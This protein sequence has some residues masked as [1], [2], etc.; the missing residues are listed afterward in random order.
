MVIEWYNISVNRR[1]KSTVWDCNYNNTRCILK[2]SSPMRKNN[3][4]DEIFITKKAQVCENVVEFIEDGITVDG[5][6]AMILK[7]IEGVQA[8]EFVK[9]ATQQQVFSLIL[10][11]MVINYQLSKLGVSFNDWHMLNVIITP[12][13][14]V[15]L[16]CDISGTLYKIPT[17]GYKVT[18]VDFGESILEAYNSERK[19]LI[20]NKGVTHALDNFLASMLF[21]QDCLS[22]CPQTLDVVKSFTFL[23]E[24]TNIVTKLI[25]KNYYTNMGL[26]WDQVSKYIY[27]SKESR[28]IFSLDAQINFNTRFVAVLVHQT[29]LKEL[30]LDVATVISVQ[31]VFNDIFKHK[32][33]LYINYI[34]YERKGKS[35]ML[36]CF[37]RT[38]EII[39]S[40]FSKSL[41]SVEFVQTNVS[42]FKQLDVKFWFDHLLQFF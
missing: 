42:N 20:F 38:R 14:V 32:G 12:T 13:S 25:R 17:C 40:I 18:V 41:D 9:C 7:Y 11:C 26:F 6:P 36:D 28:D 4:L 39:G 27:A 24:K 34:L 23:Y 1:I 35:V 33:G 2:L 31:N 19:S 30:S 8:S 5:L 16:E 37:D 21:Y 29:P 10:Q 15:S 22:H 3:F